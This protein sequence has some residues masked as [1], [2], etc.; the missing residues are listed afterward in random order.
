[1][2]PSSY[3]LNKFWGYRGWGGVGWGGKGGGELQKY[4]NFIEE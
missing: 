2:F 3:Y 1:M 4:E